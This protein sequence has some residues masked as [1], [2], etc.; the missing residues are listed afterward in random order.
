M[1]Q[2][3]EKRYKPN[4]VS[5]ILGLNKDLLRKWTEAFNIQTEWTKPEQGGHRRYSKRN[6]EELKAIKQKIHDQNW[7]WDQVRS[8]R[9]GEIEIDVFV[10]YEEKSNLEKKM[11]QLLENQKI[12]QEFYKVM[13]ERFNQIQIELLA[14]KK[15]NQKLKIH[16]IEDKFLEDLNENTTRKQEEKRKKRFWFFK[17]K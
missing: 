13:A 15:E 4:Q 16:V 6:V 17:F 5:E 11:D 7:S 2:N 8:W 9:N 3:Q 10:D 1:E 12:Q 14:I